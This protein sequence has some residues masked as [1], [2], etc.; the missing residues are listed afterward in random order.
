MNSQLVTAGYDWVVIPIEKRI[1]YMKALEKASVDEDIA[2]FC[3]FVIYLIK[4]NNS[5]IQ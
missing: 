5:T 2:D 1:D 3:R 4:T